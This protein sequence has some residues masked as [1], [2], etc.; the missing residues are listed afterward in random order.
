[1]GL[2]PGLGK[3]PAVGNG[4]PLQYSCLENLMDRA[5]WRAAV[6]RV[7]KSWTQLR[8]SMHVYFCMLWVTVEITYYCVT[9]V[10]YIFCRFVICHLN[11]ATVFLPLWS[12]TFIKVYQPFSS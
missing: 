5:A 3:S 7:T 1:M 11:L 8:D 12:F 6:C 4:R 9:S 10:A 2:I